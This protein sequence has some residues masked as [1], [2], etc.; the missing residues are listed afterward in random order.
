MK[1]SSF[2]FRFEFRDLRLLERINR[3][4]FIDG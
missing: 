4:G 3:G 1:V 2:E